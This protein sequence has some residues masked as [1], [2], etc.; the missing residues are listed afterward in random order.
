MEKGKAV[1]LD[2]DGTINKYKQYVH[3]IEEFE[4]IEGAISAIRLL[5]DSGYKVI[6]VTNQSGI[7]HGLYTLYDMQKLHD[8]MCLE[9]EKCGAR[10]DKIYFSHY[11]Q[12]VNHP[13]RKPNP[14][15]ILKGINDFDLDPKKCYMIGDTDKDMKAGKSAGCTTILVRTGKDRES[16]NADFVAKNIFEAVDKIILKGRLKHD[17]M[18]KVPQEL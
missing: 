1:F 15:M 12:S 8:Y 5:N 14:G 13:T 11:H 18:K 10:I 4:F 6:V 2:R 7:S 3:K 9:L 16:S 17:L